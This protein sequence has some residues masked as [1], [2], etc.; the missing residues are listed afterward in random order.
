MIEGLTALL[1][2]VMVAVFWRNI[3]YGLYTLLFLLPFERIGSW[4]L[5]PV[6]DHPIIRISQV[7]GLALILVFAGQLLM[8]KRKLKFP[9]LF[10]PLVGLCIWSLLPVLIIGYHPL[11]Y[12]YA[13]LVFVAVLTLVV[14]NLVSEVSLRSMLIALVSGAVVTGLFG[15]WQFV[16]GTLGVSQTLTGLRPEYTKAVFG[17]PRI[18]STGL[19]PLYYAN[20]LIIPMLVVMAMLAF[21]VIRKKVAWWVAI[22]LV[23]GLTFVLTMSRGAFIGVVIGLIAVTPFALMKR[24]IVSLKIIGIS[25]GVAVVAAGLLLVF[26]SVVS[27]HNLTSAP[28][29]FISLVTV[30]LTKTGS[31]TQ[32]TSM[33]SQ[34]AQIADSHLWFGLGI[35]GIA[36]YVHH[37]VPGS[38]TDD[39]AFNN[40]ALELV[41]QAGL[42]GAIMFY[43]FLAWLLV[44]SARRYLK[45][46]GPEE[47]AW[48]IGLAAALI[49]VTVQAQSFSG[50]L[51]T[52]LWVLYG[53]LAG[54]AYRDS[55]RSEHKELA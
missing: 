33:R 1:L 30:D 19:E 48:L 55:G 20:Y 38:S 43:V 45:T 3:R 14:A 44:A 35:E 41:D 25:A 2:V 5:N 34:A 23:I 50:F 26:A 52:H 18:Q 40:Q 7:C 39:V 12:G 31:F 13:S 6:T 16:G 47:A 46:K 10:A 28:E 53:L 15:L 8:R 21:R 9:W 29:R 49:A 37:Y 36:P 11:L 32:R 42:A 17:Y 27:D 54:F 51:L 24:R 22:L 4:P